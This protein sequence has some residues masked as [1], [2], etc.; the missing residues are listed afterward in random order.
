MF[1]MGGS[2]VMVLSDRYLF[3]MLLSVSYR[4]GLECC[5]CALYGNSV[6][7]RV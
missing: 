4:T 3:P 5:T 7:K 2:M 1:V 6:V